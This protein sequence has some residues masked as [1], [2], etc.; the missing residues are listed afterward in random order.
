MVSMGPGKSPVCLSWRKVDCAATKEGTSMPIKNLAAFLDP[1]P[2]GEARAEY[3]VKLALR[4]G[5]HL[6]GIFVVPTGWDHSESFVRG[7]DA[8]RNMIKRH[9]AEE[10]IASNAASESFKSVIGRTGVSSEF[11]IIRQDSADEQAE[12]NV[13]HADL[14]IVGH[15]RP[16]GLPH[17]WSAEALLL[18]TGVPF[19]VLPDVWRGKTA[20]ERVL[21]AWNASREARRAIADALPMLVAAQSVSIVI[22]DAHKNARH[23]EEPGADVAL[24]L[25]RHG[26][27]VAVERMQ[28]AGRAV[29]DVI[30][31]YAE[32]NNTDLIVLGAYSHARSREIL[33]G[34]VTRSL[35]ANVKVPLLIAH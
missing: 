24:Y 7:D 8:I 25:S 35:L 4:H 30:L 23:G 17:D 1:S 21:L 32:H 29:A 22:V 31:H 18:A 26:A 34:G 12:L 33:L 15:P 5:A 27:K 14:V 11:R 2:S 13:L 10:A 3:A 16:G 19:L 9:N 6:I 20:A 28:S